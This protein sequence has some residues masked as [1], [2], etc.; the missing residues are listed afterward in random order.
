[1]SDETKVDLPEAEYANVTVALKN[2]ED[3]TD[4][5]GTYVYVVTYQEKSV[6]V[7]VTF[8]RELGE[9]VVEPTEL[10]LFY[11]TEI[12]IADISSVKAH[13]YGTEEVIDVTSSENVKIGEYD[14][15]KVD[16]IQTVVITY[17]ENGVSVTDTILVLFVMPSITE[18]DVKQKDP[19]EA[20]VLKHGQ[21]TVAVDD[22][23]ALYD[24]VYVY[25]NG[26]EVAVEA[27]NIKTEVIADLEMGADSGWVE[28][29]VGEYSYDLEGLT[30]VDV[31]V[32]IS[33]TYGG[34]EVDVNA[35]L[36]ESKVTV[37]AT[38]SY[39]G[40]TAVSE[41]YELSGFSSTTE[42][43][44]TVTV[45][46]Q[47]KTA[48][49]TV[50]VNDV[51]I[52]HYY[53]YAGWTKVYAHYWI[54]DGASTDWPGVAMAQD[55][56]SKWWYITVDTDYK[57]ILFNNGAD[58]ISNPAYQTDDATIDVNNTWYVLGVW[59]ATKPTSSNLSKNTVLVDISSCTGWG[60]ANAIICVYAWEQNKDGVFYKTRRISNT[61]YV[62]NLP[63]NPY[64][65]I[66][67]RH[68]PASATPSWTQDT[69]LWNRTTGD[70]TNT[71]NR[72]IKV[73]GW[74]ATG[75]T[76]AITIA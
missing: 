40:E 45:T 16:A 55:G 15:T 75:E 58:G 10:E 42:G 61:L 32:S 25:D 6:E 24:V 73:K 5:A 30:V 72:I 50:T 33:A 26:D 35:P 27:G 41:G 57:N 62:V 9:I 44:K 11:N 22:V 56:T 1:M 20:L 68:N 23:L 54:K 63:I 49:F 17:T 59:Y 13:Y 19:N 64:G 36:D 28:V 76:A 47:G 2:S 46:Y 51:V 29:I 69:S 65:M 74:N 66:A 34:G 12:T 48:N 39:A 21:E 4:V 52:I 67:T 60:D 37:K 43:V 71:T 14:K 38:Y 70:I 53:N 3:D 31:L 8:T 7:E 18:I